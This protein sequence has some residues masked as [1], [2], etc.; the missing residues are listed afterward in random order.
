[1]TRGF[2]ADQNTASQGRDLYGDGS[3]QVLALN[4][5]LRSESYNRALLEA[6]DELAPQDVSVEIVDLHSLPLY[7]ADHDE[8]LG[9]YDTPDEVRWLKDRI[10]AADALLVATPEYNWSVSGVLK[11]AIDW[12]SRPAGRSVLA[13]KPAA[14]VGASPGPAGTGRAQLH[15]RQI[16][17][18]TKTPVLMDSVQAGSARERFDASGHLVDEHVRAQLYG[19][20]QGL[21]A[22]ARA[23]VSE[24]PS[25]T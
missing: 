16:L 2:V 13:G 5:S 25:R 1:M 9:G 8:E 4:G 10:A 21:A 18:S 6:A 11:N 7:N 24:S 15:L 12:A 23:L 14:L 19:V 20:L 17:L 3:L 22:E